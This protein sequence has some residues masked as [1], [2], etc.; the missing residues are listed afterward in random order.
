[1]QNWKIVNE[2]G[3]KQKVKL[4]MMENNEANNGFY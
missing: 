3:K 4:K 2:D 1:M